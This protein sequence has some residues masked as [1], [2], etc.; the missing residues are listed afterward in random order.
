[1]DGS[2]GLAKF[3]V[4]ILV[5]RFSIQHS[6]ALSHSFVD[7][8]VGLEPIFQLESCYWRA[9]DP[10]QNAINKKQWPGIGSR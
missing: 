4:S 9:K 5:L 2:A 1:M 6:S 3:G 10:P 8:N 7:L